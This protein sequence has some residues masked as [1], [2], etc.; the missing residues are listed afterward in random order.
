MGRL[1]C[2]YLLKYFLKD[3][4]LENAFNIIHIISEF[5]V[6]KNMLG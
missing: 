3:T 5:V 6:P 4:G 1:R 2:D